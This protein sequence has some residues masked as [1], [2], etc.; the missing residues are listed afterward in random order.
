[1]SGDESLMLVLLFVVVMIS[2]WCAA[3]DGDHWS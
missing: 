3:S 2:L 1:M